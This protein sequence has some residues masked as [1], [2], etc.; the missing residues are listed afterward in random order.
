V[1]GWLTAC[2]GMEA[3][4]GSSR[5]ALFLVAKKCAYLAWHKPDCTG[6]RHQTRREEYGGLHRCA[7]GGVERENAAGVG[8]KGA[9]YVADGNLKHA[10]LERGGCGRVLFGVLTRMMRRDMR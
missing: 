7:S 6:Q 5:F 10:E 1:T 8:Y 4:R 2:A 3:Q 9:S